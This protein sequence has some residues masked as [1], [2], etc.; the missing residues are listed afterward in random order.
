[1]RLTAPIALVAQARRGRG[2]RLSG[3]SAKWT[4]TV[5]PLRREVSVGIRVR[6]A[7]ERLEVLAM[8]RELGIHPQSVR[9]WPR[10]FHEQGIPGLADRPRSGRLPPSPSEEVGE[11]IA[12]NRLPDPGPTQGPRTRSGASPASDVAST[13]SSRRRACA[14]EDRRSGSAG[15]WTP[16]SPSQGR[17]TPRP[18]EAPE[19]SAVGC[20]G[21]LGP[22][23][24]KRLPGRRLLKAWVA[25]Q[26]PRPAARA[27]QGGRRRTTGEGNGLGAPPPPSGEAFPVS[28]G[29]RGRAGSRT[30]L[31][32][33]TTCV[34]AGPPTGSGAPGPPPPGARPSAQGGYRPEPDRAPGGGVAFTYP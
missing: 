9:L 24:A 22:E 12:T 29:S 27:R 10:R 11:V 14:G 13:R 20:L 23:G 31:P 15:R 19:E 8:V 5:G 26:G 1:M 30:S 25:S 3:A 2:R 32:S 21:E 16:R 33:S 4:V 17:I 6:L 18:A 34:P 7:G 28:P